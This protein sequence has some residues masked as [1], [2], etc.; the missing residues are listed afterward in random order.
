MFGFG[1]FNRRQAH[2]FLGGAMRAR[3]APEAR[4]YSRFFNRYRSMPDQ[5]ESPFANMWRTQ[6][7]RYQ[8]QMS[9]Q[10]QVYQVGMP[11][12]TQRPQRPQ[13]V[14]SRPRP[15]R[16][17]FY[18]PPTGESKDVMNTIQPVSSTPAN[19]GGGLSGIPTDFNSFVSYRRK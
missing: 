17:S 9:P 5:W 8:H 12:F 1:G 6:M 18:T 10:G 15:Q 11:Q 3:S 19:S 2:Q 13:R 14:Q 7:S 16:P 4:A